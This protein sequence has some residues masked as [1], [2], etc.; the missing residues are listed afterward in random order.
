MKINKATGRGD[1]LGGRTV[2]K[3]HFCFEEVTCELALDRQEEAT[4]PR[5]G[6]GTPPGVRLARDLFLKVH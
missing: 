2:R 6:G 5:A 4:V 3:G 1:P